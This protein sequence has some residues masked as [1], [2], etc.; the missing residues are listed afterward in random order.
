MV[1]VFGYFWPGKLQPINDE[2]P[3]NAIWLAF[4][5]ALEI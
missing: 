5:S 4:A 3:E 2:T 1:S